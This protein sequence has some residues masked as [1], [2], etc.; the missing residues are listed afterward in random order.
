MDPNAALARIRELVAE[1]DGWPDTSEHW[2]VTASELAETVTGLDT[3]LS[4]G[5]FLPLAWQNFGGQKVV[6]GND[7]GWHG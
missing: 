7:V 4:S 6:C 2:I 3:W 5:G 1:L